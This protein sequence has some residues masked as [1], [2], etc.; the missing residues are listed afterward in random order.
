MFVAKTQ[1]ILSSKYEWHIPQLD[2]KL[3]SR[4]ENLFHD[5]VIDFD[6]L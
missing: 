3:E 6:I 5:P 1:E 4:H 2:L